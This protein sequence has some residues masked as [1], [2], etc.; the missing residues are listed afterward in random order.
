MNSIVIPSKCYCGGFFN[1]DVTI[2]LL[3][4]DISAF[5]DKAFSRLKEKIKKSCMICGRQINNNQK[6]Y[7]VE[8]YKDQKIN[9]PHIICSTCY[10]NNIRTRP[11]MI[12]CVLCGFAHDISD[13]VFPRRKNQDA[14]C[15][16]F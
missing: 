4:N 15:K 14:C 5:S 6:T 12:F 3:H 7:Y 11:R 9:E 2:E 16:M 1:Y 13:S 10:R 8:L